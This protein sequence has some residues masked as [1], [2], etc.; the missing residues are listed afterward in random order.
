[1]HS[2]IDMFHPGPTMSLGHHEGAEAGLGPQLVAPSWGLSA[3]P[4]SAATA[5]V[6]A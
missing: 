5:T 4:R 2:H 6:Y 3:K 1:M